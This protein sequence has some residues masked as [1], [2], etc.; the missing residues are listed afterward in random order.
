MGSSGQVFEAIDTHDNRRVAL[1]I[2]RAKKASTMQAKMEIKILTAIKEDKIADADEKHI[3]TF[4]IDHSI[5][6]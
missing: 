1:K 3:G 5:A 2:Y 4:N 6:V